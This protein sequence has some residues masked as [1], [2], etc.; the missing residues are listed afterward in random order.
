LI[1]KMKTDSEIQKDVMAELKWEASINAVKP[2]EI[3]V[4]VKNGVVT[5]LGTLDSYYKKQAAENAAMRVGGA[6]AVVN[7]IDVRIWTGFKKT[8]TEI[9]EAV[10]RAINW[11]TS[12]PEDSI[13]VKVKE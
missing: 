1:S 7:N 2:S 8:D 3:G 13:K 10:V 5:L 4:T 11:S 9:A 12:I 6:S